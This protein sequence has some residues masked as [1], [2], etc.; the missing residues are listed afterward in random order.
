[1]VG[2]RWQLAALQQPPPVAHACGPV[3]SVVQLLPLQRTPPLHDPVP[4]QV[5]VLPA[6]SA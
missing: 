3:Q 1:L 2:I 4:R 5:T 6:A